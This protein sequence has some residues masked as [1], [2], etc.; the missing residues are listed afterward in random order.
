MTYMQ[1]AL[2]ILTYADRP[3]TVGELTS[4]A[5]A[6]GLVHPRGRTP[7]RTMSSVLYRRMVADPDAPITS[8]DGRFWLRGRALPEHAAA[9]LRPGVRR[10]RRGLRSGDQG[11]PAAARARRSRSVTVLPP[12][13]LLVTV[14]EMAAMAARSRAGDGATRR[15]RAVARL[16]LDLRTLAAR[17]APGWSM[18]AEW[19]PER[20]GARLV[21]PLL[22]LLGYRRADQRALSPVRGRDA[23]VLL[24]GAIPT[25]LLE[26]T[27]AVHVLGD[28]DA[29]STLLRAAA[30]GVPWALLTNGRELRLYVTAL[31]A[32][33][34]EP[35][36][37][38]VLRADAY[39]WSDDQTR[40]EVAR[41]LWLLSRAAVANGSLD[42]YL[43][44]RAVGAALLGSL[45]DPAS[46]LVRALGEAVRESVG[47]SL[48]P[49]MIARQARL[50]VRGVRGRDGEPLPSEITTVA[51]VSGVDLVQRSDSQETLAA[52]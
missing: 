16:S 45:D 9:A 51:A 43:A 2:S 11:Q 36:A 41:V 48:A 24:V 23:R 12:P 28:S 21:A 37:A 17:L 32:G 1:A 22:T 29:R 7:D 31:D 26:C 49:E 35:S 34:A 6:Q 44:A 5:V 10:V 38:L 39:A 15:D 40:L 46:P 4:I 13:P 14:P 20:L 50:A 3:L 52:S 8:A 30:A 19:E 27:R 18:A 47:L 33:L 25:I 42:A